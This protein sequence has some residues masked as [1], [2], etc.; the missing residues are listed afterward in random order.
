[1]RLHKAK[2][3]WPRKNKQKQRNGV[4]GTHGE[5]QDEHPLCAGH[6]VGV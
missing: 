3:L 1:M 5:A 2:K 6:K 4:K